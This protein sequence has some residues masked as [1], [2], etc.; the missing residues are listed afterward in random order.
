MT[1]PGVD[2]FTFEVL[3][4]RLASIAEEG[5][6]AIQRVSGSSLAT[7][8][9]DL[10][11]SLMTPD[12]EVAF[13][14]PYVLT[15]PMSQG[16]IV[17]W[18]L[19]NATGADAPR[20][21]DVYLSNDPYAGAAHQNCV[22]LVAPIDVGDERVG[23][24]GATL[25]VVDVGGP[26][27]GQVGIGARSILEEAPPIAPT[28]IA[29]GGRILPD[30]EA[31]YL[32]RSRTPE[33]NGLDLRAKL[34]GLET[35]RARVAELVAEHGVGTVR[36][37]LDQTIEAGVR[38]LRRR[39]AELPATPAVHSAFVDQE[40]EGRVR[41]YEV[42]LRVERRGDRLRFDFT[43]SSRQAGAIVNCTRGGL[44]SGVVVGLLTTLVWDAP[45]CPAAIERSIEIVT[46]PGTV[47]DASWP[48]GC[49]MATMAAGFAA[50]TATAQTVGQLLAASPALRDRAMASWAGAV[51]SV[52]LFGSDVHGR[53]FGTVLLD[54][55]ASGTGAR[56]DADGIDSGGFLRSISAVVANAEAYEARYP[57]LYLWRRHEPDTGGAGR[58]R[59]GA[60]VG[61]AVV[62]HGVD[63]VPTVIP[64]F[65]GTLEPESIGLL[66]GLPGATNGV[67]VSRR[68]GARQA[69][70][71]GRIPEAPAAL[72]ARPRRL[73]GVVQIALEQDDAL[74][75]VTGGGGGWGDPLEREPKAVARDVRSGLVSEAAARQVY[76]VVLG[77]DGRTDELRTT[78]ARMRI[79]RRRVGAIRGRAR[80]AVP[81]RR[82]AHEV[83]GAPPADGM[84]LVRGSATPALRCPRCGW[85]STAADAIDPVD[86]LASLPAVTRPLAIGAASTR[87]TRAAATGFGL[88]ERYCPAC[89]RL[90]SVTRVHFDSMEDPG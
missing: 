88:V 24:C 49:S 11:T 32:G 47:V 53:P 44:L 1:R 62:P 17:R 64:H 2:P 84:A 66:G 18:L 16:L 20:P 54:S 35:I 83:P 69:L 79:R 78:S 85:A 40:E 50:T 67:L 12:G 77:T 57:I 37:V 33:L 10:N 23:W 26:T 19:A 5:A 87:R 48:A 45:W 86:A 68:S 9:L 43:G 74:L 76:G 58:R 73:P 75:V 42:R 25:H 55:M 46:E 31:V 81:I 21:G 29:A 56:Q 61:Y 28:R 34:A 59:G 72:R 80:P 3:R 70:A 63:R 51:G 7:E 6:L 8:A 41:H 65:A 13:I 71:D 82:P 4:H 22:T 39:I 15:G 14:G 52:D 60:G 27:S 90:V 36:A 30:A 89:L 38:H